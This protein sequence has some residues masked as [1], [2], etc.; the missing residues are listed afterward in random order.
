M[1][2][3][4]QHDCVVVIIAGGVGT[5][6]WPLSTPEKPKQFLTLFGHRSMLQGTYDRIADLV[7]PERTLVL[8][9]DRYVPLVRE[10]LPEI[11]EQNIIGEPMR[12]D[13]AAA[14]ALAAFL[15][16]RRFSNPSMIVL[17]ADHMIQPVREFQKALLS[18]VQAALRNGALYTFGI[19]PEYAATG[20][21][22]LERGEQIMED[23]G[24]GHF[25]L[26][27]F[28]E[29][30]D[31]ATAEKYLAEGSFLWNSG[32]FVWTTDAIL[33]EIEKHLPE[34]ICH[35][36]PLMTYD[37]TQDWPNALHK[38]FTEVPSISI[39]YG[40]MEKASDVRIVTAPF[41]WSDVGGWPAVEAFLE[42]DNQ[43]NACRGEVRG[44]D[45]SANLVFSEDTEEVI[46]I[47]GVNDLI[48][49]RSGKKTLIVPR[50]R[51]EEVKKLVES[52]ITIG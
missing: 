20:Y 36:R 22:Y 10:Q 9:N 26:R 6:F 32:M 42:K 5:R 40:I 18:A 24:C 2:I 31:R 43:G 8:T 21:G 34:Y 12:R 41:S 50:E 19:R 25:R 30:P 49:V 52:P 38:A 13:T 47:I 1:V 45:A 48:V 39:D 4:E 51:A 14:V 16:R 46:T 29:K 15:C 7:T 44:L 33:T 23:G 28:K 35:F 11:P 3:S 17:P 37:G 27:R